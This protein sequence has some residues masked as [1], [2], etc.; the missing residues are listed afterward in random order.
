[1][2]L[3]MADTIKVFGSNIP[4]PIAIGGGA[5]VLV[6]G[7]YY[8]RKNKTERAN[9]QSVTDAGTNEI[10]PAT[11]YP[12]GSPEDAAALQTQNSYASVG[13]GG[14]GYTG[15]T[16]GSGSGV[17]GTGAPGSFNSNA[18]WAQFVEQYEIN[19]MGGDAPTIGN[20]IG[21][22][23]TGQPLITDAMV[24]IIQSAIAIGGYPPVSG[25]NGNPP[26]YVTATTGTTTPPPPPPPPG[27]T[28]VGQAK[29]IT[30]LKIINKTKTSV[31][32]GWNATSAP[33][34]YNYMLKQLNGTVVTNSQTT[35]HQVTIGGLHSGW[36]YNFSIH[37]IPNGVGNA[38]HVSKL[39]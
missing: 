37:G 38:I 24:S 2:V 3:D 27:N 7:I 5:L 18:E 12:Y 32:I 28:G 30:G 4:K 23:L 10:D 25:P 20:A 8:Y 16:G 39:A 29:P 21:K 14:Y 22:Y 31:T 6:G 26:G 19:N 13:G 1:L 33:Q 9:A 15:Y 34:G 17:F 11:G 35:G 36:E